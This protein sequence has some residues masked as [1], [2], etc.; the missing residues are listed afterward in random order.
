[1]AAA[2]STLAVVHI[3][4]KSIVTTRQ[5]EHTAA[6]VWQQKTAQ[7]WPPYDSDIAFATSGGSQSRPLPTA[8]HLVAPFAGPRPSTPFGWW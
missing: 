2:H 5:R 6:L 7:A 3:A 1:M 4:A 8:A